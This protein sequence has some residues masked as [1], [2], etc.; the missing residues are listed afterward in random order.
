MILSLKMALRS[1]GSN[2]MRAVLTM[3]G[4][5]I[6]VVALVVLV[7]L[8]DGATSSVTD[9]LSGLGSSLLTATIEDDKGYPI[10]MDNLSEWAEDHEAIGL[11]APYISD[12]ITGSAEG[13]SGSFTVY[14]TVP[15]YYDIQ[16]ME[17]V[18]GRFLKTA[19]IQKSSYV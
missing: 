19:D 16:G 18:M 3:L 13:E 11:M 4:I 14:G 7:S 9:I 8:V 5:I 17:L 2:K 15:E 6:G 12:S 10:T 1:I